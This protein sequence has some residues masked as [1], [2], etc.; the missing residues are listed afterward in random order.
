MEESSTNYGVAV[1]YLKTYINQ[2]NQV[3]PLIRVVLNLHCIFV[4]QDGSIVIFKPI[5]EIN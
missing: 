5:D 3:K 1:P 4:K 2:C